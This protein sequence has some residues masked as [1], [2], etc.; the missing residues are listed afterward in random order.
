MLSSFLTTSFHNFTDL[1]LHRSAR[2]RP[3]GLLGAGMSAGRT[4]TGILGV[5]LARQF[6]GGY[7][8]YK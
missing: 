6:L 7:S 3:A 4:M 2:L 5:L 8:L 1:M